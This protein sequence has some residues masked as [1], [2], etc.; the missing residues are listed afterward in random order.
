M[1]LHAPAPRFDFERY[2]DRKFQ[3]CERRCKDGVTR[4]YAAGHGFLWDEYRA[5]F[6]D[7]VA[8]ARQ[9][10]EHVVHRKLGCAMSN[11]IYHDFKNRVIDAWDDPAFDVGARELAWRI[12]T[13]AT[14]RPSTCDRGT[15]LARAPIT[16]ETLF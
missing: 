6:C 2:F 4:T 16:I 12:H 7:S 9:D 11:Y 13:L 3:R 5:I 8:W 14:Q 10:D 15:G 1:V